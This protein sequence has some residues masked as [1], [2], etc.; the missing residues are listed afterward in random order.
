MHTFIFGDIRKRLENKKKTNGT[1]EFFLSSINYFFFIFTNKTQS[2][3]FG[4]HLKFPIPEKE[5][6]MYLCASFT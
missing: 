2:L 3:A 6:D 1:E 5:L 4:A